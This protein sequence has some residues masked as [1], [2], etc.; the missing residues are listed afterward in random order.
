ML[1]YLT[2]MLICDTS[3]CFST[4]DL[5]YLIRYFNISEI[6][7]PLWIKSLVK[8]LESLKSI[9]IEDITY[10]IQHFNKFL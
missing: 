2:E 3:S 10:F 8:A 1:S 5:Y 4:Y 9:S 6:F 7:I